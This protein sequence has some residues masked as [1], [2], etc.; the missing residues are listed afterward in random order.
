DE[1]VGGEVW[2]DDVNNLAGSVSTATEAANDVF[3]SDELGL[4]VRLGRGA[5]FGNF[6]YGFRLEG[7]GMIRWEIEAVRQAVENILALADGVRAFAP[8]DSAAAA[9]EDEGG[10]FALG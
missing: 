8:I 7:D 6:A 10:F 5:A 4:K 3:W 9:E 2:A 1:F